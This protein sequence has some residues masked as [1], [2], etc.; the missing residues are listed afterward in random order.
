ML[1]LG[2]PL[3]AN[4]S[5]L[6]QGSRG[7][8]GVKDTRPSADQ[9]LQLKCKTQKI[10]QDNLQKGSQVHNL[11]RTRKVRESELD[12]ELVWSVWGLN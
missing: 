5:W 12:T 2:L 3:L 10:A 4:S 11:T 8:R 9:L 7:E 1:V 6:N